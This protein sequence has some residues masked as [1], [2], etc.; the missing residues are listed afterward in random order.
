MEQKLAQ[1]GITMSKEEINAKLK[2]THCL[3][4]E[5]ETF[6]EELALGDAPVE[7]IFARYVFAP[8]GKDMAEEDVY[9]YS[10]WYYFFEKLGIDPE[11]LYGA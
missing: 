6:C 4:G 8:R 2:G 5:Y 11:Q 9:Q 10:C 3:K 1:R 7:Q